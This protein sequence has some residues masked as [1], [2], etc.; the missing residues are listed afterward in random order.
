MHGIHRT[1]CRE[2]PP[3]DDTDAHRCRRVW[4]PCHTHADKFCEFCEFCGRK[5]I[6][7]ERTELTETS[8][9]EET[10]TD[11]T[12]EHRCRRVWHPCRTHADKFCE[13]C[14]RKD[15]PAE[16]TEHT[17][18]SGREE[19]PTD[20]HGCSQI[21]RVW[22]PCH[23]HA[24]KFCEFCEFCG[25]TAHPKYLCKSVKSVGEKIFQQNARNL[26]VEKSLPQ[27][28]TDAHRCRRV[29]HSC[30]THAAKFCV[31]CEFCGRTA[32]PKYLCKSVK[33]VGEKIF[34]QNARNAQNLL[35]RRT[36][37]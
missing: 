24:D 32:H 37:H 6:P 12:D 20:E 27:M 22:H 1:S 21:R 31:F 30:H 10:P 25:R 19:P 33:S 3:T 4:H 9:R 2:E 35:Q 7:T 15:I 11:D 13:F 14:G 36:S 26:L 29:W 23:T 8:G 34:Q 16:R 18:T 17:E 5:E 28:S